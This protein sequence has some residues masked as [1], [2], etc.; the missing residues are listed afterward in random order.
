ML[1]VI[2]AEEA[3][4]TCEASL[5]DDGALSVLASEP[6]SVEM[7]HALAMASQSPTPRIV[8]LERDRVLMELQTVGRRSSGEELSG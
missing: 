6:L 4:A 7:E 2:R 5:R 1:L 3:L 8:R